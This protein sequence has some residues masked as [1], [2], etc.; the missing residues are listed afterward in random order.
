MRENILRDLA[1]RAATEPT[2]LR[3]ARQDL[4]GTLAGFGYDL[5]LGELRLVAARGLARSG[6]RSRRRRPEGGRRKGAPDR[7]APGE[8]AVEEP[9][10]LG[11]LGRSASVRR[12][13]AR[14]CRPHGRPEGAQDSLLLRVPQKG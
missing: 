4:R 9:E 10:V 14:H 11:A 3:Q 2:F 13:Q 6:W 7:G 8:P 12:V 1:S 5:T